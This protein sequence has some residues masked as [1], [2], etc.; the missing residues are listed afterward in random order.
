M[1]AILGSELTLSTI[2]CAPSVRPRSILYKRCVLASK[3][4]RRTADTA[5]S[6]HLLCGK[7]ISPFPSRMRKAM[8]SYEE[9][10]RPSP[11][12]ILAR[13]EAPAMMIS[14]CFR[15]LAKSNNG[16]IHHVAW[17][18]VHPIVTLVWPFG[19]DSAIRETILQEPCP[20]GADKAQGSSAAHK[21]G[22]GTSWRLACHSTRVVICA[23]VPWCPLMSV[24]VGVKGSQSQGQSSWMGLKGTGESQGDCGPTFP[25][26]S[27]KH[28]QSQGTGVHIS[29][30]TFEANPLVPTTPL[31][32][33][34]NTLSLRYWGP[35][36]PQKPSARAL[37]HPRLNLLRQPPT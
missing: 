31:D 32:D 19:R 15:K 24:I 36:K 21:R 9:Y 2:S 8:G 28:G 26:K 7:C 30:P 20:C 17:L 23:M 11:N 6:I 14:H 5:T 12:Q 3:H 13:R 35:L 1:I 4:R 34:I 25:V 27:G 37:V 22:K 16:V 18:G 10:S 33:T 29:S